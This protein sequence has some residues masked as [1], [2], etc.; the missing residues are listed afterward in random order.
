MSG[1]RWGSH[2]GGI[3]KGHHRRS[4]ALR[5][6]AVAAALGAVAAACGGDN[7][8]GSSSSTTAATGATA[9]AGKPVRG[10]SI[11]IGLEAENNTGWF[12][13]DAQCAVSCAYVTNAVFDPLMKLDVD[14]NL[15]PWL[16][17]D[18]KPNADATVWTVKLRQGVKFQNGED[19]NAE[20]V[21]LNL[22]AGKAGSVLSL[23]L[24]P[25]QAV[26]VIDTY[27]VEIDSTPWGALPAS[28][29]AQGFMMAAPAQVKAKDKNHP[30]GTGAFGFKE[31]VPNDHL[32]L[33]RNPS[34]WYKDPKSGD[35][36]PYLDEVTF[37]PIPEVAAREA[38]LKS[39]QID[40][41]HTSNGNEIAK[42]K[43][44]K[45]FTAV[46]Q[47]KPA[48]TG[49]FLIN[50]LVPGLDDVRVRQALAYCLDRDALNKQRGGGLTPPA[51]G[52]FPPGSIGFLDDNGYPKTR[53]IEKAKQLIADY[54]K[55]KGKLPTFKFG[56]TNDPFNVETNQLVQAQW[57]ECG[58]N[59]NILQIEQTQ[60]ITEAG[61]GTDQFQIFAWRNH[62]FADTD[63]NFYFWSSA[64]APPPGK[65]AINFGRMVDPQI[66][67]ALK[68]E[69]ESV[70]PAARKQASQDLNRIMGSK[71]EAIWANWVVWANIAKTNVH[72]L[73]DF[74]LENGK[75][76][77]PVFFPGFLNL[78][79]AWR[80]A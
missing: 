47:D 69:R 9:A 37:K 10:G 75:T 61:N 72:G 2:K 27:T 71:A 62:G 46:M 36:L 38:A 11:S 1:M 78:H 34:Y 21:K 67:A 45:A 19:F 55:E 26:K 66:D 68:T 53:D 79:N 28:F 51:N 31:W 8:E 74:T 44:D 80:S 73:N 41:M 14:G 43:D 35:Q 58:I 56:T 65:F 33:V 20:A 17:L 70:D 63:G 77:L 29:P 54:E 48:E 15:Q 25:I 13:P 7:K 39:G 18:A 59:T 50:Q 40:V 42:L 4:F 64:L 76:A 3:V 23:A 12:M 60:Y 16:A 52:P 22:D 6:L 30:I 57:Q 32:T 24:A 49:Y 5:S